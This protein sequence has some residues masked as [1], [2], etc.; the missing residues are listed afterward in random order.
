MSMQK[1][2]P[3]LRPS[4]LI[5][6]ELPVYKAFHEGKVISLINPLWAEFAAKRLQLLSIL[7]GQH[8]DTWP[9]PE[10]YEKYLSLYPDLMPVD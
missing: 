4:E 7:I 6:I 3:M 1:S 10:T 2:N 8:N 5:D 9:N